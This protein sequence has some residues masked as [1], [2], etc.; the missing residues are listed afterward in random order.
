MSVPQRSSEPRGSGPSAGRQR[1]NRTAWSSLLSSGSQSP[2]L[3]T[4]E[5]N[6][7]Q[8]RDN[9]HVSTVKKQ[10]TNFTFSFWLQLP[11]RKLALGTKAPGESLSLLKCSAQRYVLSA[12]SSF[13]TGTKHTQTCIHTL[14]RSAKQMWGGNNPFLLPS[15]ST[16][17]NRK[18]RLQFCC[19]TWWINN[20]L[21]AVALISLRSWRMQETIL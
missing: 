7:E 20:P 14:A 4:K 15:L 5:R 13:R 11:G 19:L 6:T 1:T 10:T 16:E 8:R 9:Q 12:P 17:V 2:W 3:K 21:E 18:N